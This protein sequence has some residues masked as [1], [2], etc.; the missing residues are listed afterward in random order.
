MARHYLVG[1]AWIVY[2]LGDIRQVVAITMKVQVVNSDSP[3]KSGKWLSHSQNEDM[4]VWQDAWETQLKEVSVTLTCGSLPYIIGF[5]LFHCPE[6]THLDGRKHSEASSSP[7]G[8]HDAKTKRVPQEMNL[9]KASRTHSHQLT[10]SN[11]ESIV[12]HW[13]SSYVRI[14]MVQ[15][16][17]PNLQAGNHALI[18]EAPRNVS[19][20][21]SNMAR[22]ENTSVVWV[23]QMIKETRR[24]I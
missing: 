7:C 8:G 21:N 1:V 5:I 11:Y 2:K 3:K 14:L 10:S 17:P 16:F 6:L 22:L 23:H 4:S 20:W 24:C 15:E 19:Y 13:S 12:I 18:L 9:S